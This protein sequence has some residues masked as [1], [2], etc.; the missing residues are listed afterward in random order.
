MPKFDSVGDKAP[1][2][3]KPVSSPSD[4]G[5][6]GTFELGDASKA[7]LNRTPIPSPTDGG[8]SGKFDLGDASAAPLNRSPVKGWGSAA[9]LP[10]SERAEAQSQVKGKRGR[11]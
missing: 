4:Q 2:S 1:L 10:M 7:P 3:H 9:T 11:K 6:S 5:K 8:S